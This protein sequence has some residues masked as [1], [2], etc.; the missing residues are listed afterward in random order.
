M[1]SIWI[2]KRP[3]VIIPNIPRNI[4]IAPLLEGNETRRVGST[5]TGSTVLDRLAVIVISIF[6]SCKPKPSS[7]Y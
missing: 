5:N 4:T 3:P 1:E 6:L 2:S 7:T